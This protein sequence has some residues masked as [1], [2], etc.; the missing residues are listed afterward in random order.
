MPSDPFAFATLPVTLAAPRVLTKIPTLALLSA[1][2]PVGT[3]PRVPGAIS[4][5][6]LRCGS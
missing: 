1:W 2:F 3:A 4:I 5:P 6:W